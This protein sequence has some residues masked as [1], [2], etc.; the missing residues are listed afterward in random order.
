MLQRSKPASTIGLNQTPR[1]SF[2]QCVGLS[3]RDVEVLP[4]LWESLWVAAVS[5][6]RG[7]IHPVALPVPVPSPTVGEERDSGRG[8]IG[9]HQVSLR[10][11][12][13]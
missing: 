12:L 4:E 2:G 13:I 8:P 1:C 5:K 9:P 7:S 11:L 6:L 3:H 10:L